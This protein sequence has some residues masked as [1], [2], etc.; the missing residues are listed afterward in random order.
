MDDQQAVDTSGSITTRNVGLAAGALAAFKGADLQVDRAIPGAPLSFIVS[1]IPADFS[2]QVARG[3]L[4]V[5]LSDMI[6][7]TA[8]LLTLIRESKRGGRA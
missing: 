2:E 8:H 7:W 5:N 1:K 6:A 3:T 4:T